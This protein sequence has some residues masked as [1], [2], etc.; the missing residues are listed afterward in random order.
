MPLWDPAKSSGIFHW[1]REAAHVPPPLQPGAMEL[2]LP[3]KCPSSHQSRTGVTPW[4]C[5]GCVSALTCS[6]W[7]SV[8]HP[9]PPS[10][11]ILVQ[12]GSRSSRDP[13]TPAGRFSLSQ[14]LI[15]DGKACGTSGWVGKLGRQIE[16]VVSDPK[17][18]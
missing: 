7:V 3:R 2:L 12:Q 15:L 14:A 8:P 13:C 6:G 18:R 9:S 5:L 17:F 1:D 11:G 10:A 4:L 16:R